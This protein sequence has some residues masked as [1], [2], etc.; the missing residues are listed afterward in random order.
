MAGM[1]AETEGKARGGADAMVMV[2][3]HR[4]AVVADEAI[5]K[6]GMMVAVIAGDDALAIHGGAAGA[7]VVSKAAAGAGAMA[8]TVKGLGAGRCEDCKAGGDSEEGD[9]LL[10]DLREVWFF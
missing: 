3:A 9:E 5:A 10:H 2:M 4:A 6:D 1:A 8:V 7:A